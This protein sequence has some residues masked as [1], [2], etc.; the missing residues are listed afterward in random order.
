[1]PKAY[2]FTELIRRLRNYDPRFR[3][4]VERGK[5]SHRMLYHPDISGQERSYALTFHGKIPEYGKGTI[6]AIKRR[7]DLPDGVL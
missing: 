4:F 1:M 7:F 6:A 5:G 2:R 3:V